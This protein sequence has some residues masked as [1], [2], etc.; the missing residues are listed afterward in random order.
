MR[1]PKPPRST[2]TPQL[3]ER[4]AEMLVHALRRPQA[5]PLREAW[6]VA[7]RRVGD[8]R[9]LADDEDR[10]A[11]VEDAPVELAL[12]VLEDPQPCDAAG[13]AS[14]AASSSSRATPS[15]T[16]RP[17]PISP[18]TSS[19]TRTR[20]SVTRWMTARNGYSSARSRAA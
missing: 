7:L 12:V 15:R 1:T 17:G 16:H 14:A 20:A 19:S 5:E 3:A 6:P 8:E 9:E 2:G 10:A 11:R 18:T 4:G 13:E